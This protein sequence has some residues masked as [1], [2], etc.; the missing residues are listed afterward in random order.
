MS[1]LPGLQAEPASGSKM[2]ARSL[3]Y[4]KDRL[5]WLGGQEAA[6]ASNPR[7]N[8]SDKVSS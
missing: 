3:N 5:L 8:Q 6:I 1:L 4:I 2:E 7:N